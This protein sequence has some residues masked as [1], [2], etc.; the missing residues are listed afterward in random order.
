MPLERCYDCG[1]LLKG[2]HLGF[3]A[4]CKCYRGRIPKRPVE[5][6]LAERPRPDPILESDIAKL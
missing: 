2:K 1:G 6:T 5:V 4:V 3:E